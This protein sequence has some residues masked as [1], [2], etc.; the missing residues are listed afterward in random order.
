MRFYIDLEATRF[1]NR[2]ISIGVVAEN[3][4]SYYSL[5]K[6]AGKVKVD[7]FI[8]ALTGITNEMVAAAPTADEV[9]NQVFD[10]IELNNNTFPPEYYVYG[11]SDGC[12]F[13][14]TIKYM[15]DTRAIICA[16][17][18][19][20]NLIDYSA[21]VKKFFSTETDIALRKVYM[22]IQHQT[23]LVQK[24]NA[25]EDA[26][27]LQSVVENMNRKCRPEDKEAMLAI[28]S[29]PK[30]I[31]RK[32]APSKFLEWDNY[33]RADAP[34]GATEDN[35]L[36]KAT[37]QNNG[38][39]KYFNDYNTAALWIIKYLAKKLSP[40]NEEHVNRVKKAIRDGAENKKCRYNCY[41]EIKE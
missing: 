38:T 2:I 39:A 25:L 28:P 23:E 5:V 3:G 6:P 18:I 27:M 30:L 37:D 4:K 21:E 36:I 35:Y 33:T 19:A 20:G 31:T 24:H 29:Q 34:T 40:K 26:R 11:N 41:W 15:T 32:R 7:K 9:F 17:A 14:H 1:S 22:I 12:F 16:Q 10:F 8:T 13:E